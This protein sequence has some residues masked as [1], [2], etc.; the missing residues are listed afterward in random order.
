[1][2]YL[3]NSTTLRQYMD[4]LLRCY[5]STEKYNLIL[6][7]VI[8]IARVYAIIFFMQTG[9]YMTDSHYEN[10]LVVFRHGNLEVLFIDFGQGVKIPDDE[11][12]RLFGL[13]K[14]GL[15]QD[16]LTHICREMGCTGLKECHWLC[17]FP[18]K[19]ISGSVNPF[20][21]QGDSFNKL[22][23]QTAP[24]ELLEKIDSDKGPSLFSTVHSAVVYLGKL[25]GLVRPA[26]TDSVEPSAKRRR[27]GGT[28]KKRSKTGRTRST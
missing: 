26:T 19:N 4:N 5:K 21:L 8:N 9:Y 23:R 12:A 16:I 11:Y 18:D 22:F 1:M 2:E 25:T 27:Y 24:P 6:T 15:Y 14:S 3:E 7:K 20:A 13:L 17:H 10:I 28:K